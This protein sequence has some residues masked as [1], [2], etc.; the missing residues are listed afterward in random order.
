MVEFQEWLA[1]L[2]GFFFAIREADA[3][4]ANDRL[5]AHWRNEDTNTLNSPSLALLAK[6]M[7]H[8]TNIA[9][10]STVDLV[11]MKVINDMY[12]A[13]RFFKM[14]GHYVRI[15]AAVQVYLQENNHE[16]VIWNRS[17]SAQQ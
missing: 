12:M 4:P 3:H 10:V 15:V 14:G 2:T 9:C 6:C 1:K 7:N 13:V 11:G 16:H 5:H 8:Q 17:P